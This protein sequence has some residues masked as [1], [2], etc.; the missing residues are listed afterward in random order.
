MFYSE[1]CFFVYVGILC[2]VLL[3][4][5]VSSGKIIVVFVSV[6]KLKWLWISKFNG[7]LV[8]SVL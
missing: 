5:Q 7:V 3:N 1:G 4:V 6:V 8:V 2:M